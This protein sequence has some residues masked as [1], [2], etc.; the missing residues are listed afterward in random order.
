MALDRVGTTTCPECRE[1][2]PVFRHSRAVPGQPLAI[3]VHFVGP[4]YCK[5]VGRHVQPDQ[6]TR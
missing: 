2:V 4:T 1:T 6:V 3:S 5:G